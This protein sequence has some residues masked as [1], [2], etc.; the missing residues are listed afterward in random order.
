MFKI[1][2]FFKS[3][4]GLKTTKKVNWKQF[5]KLLYEPKWLEVNRTIP[6]SKKNRYVKKRTKLVTRIIVCKYLNP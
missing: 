3:R 6:L 1:I 4:F 2:F 5:L